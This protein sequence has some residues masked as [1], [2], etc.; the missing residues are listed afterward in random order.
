[1]DFREIVAVSVVVLIAGCG[2]EG[3]G[4]VEAPVLRPEPVATIHMD[5]TGCLSCEMCRATMRR[6]A[7]QDG[8]DIRFEGDA[9]E[10]DCR[11]EEP[12]SFTELVRRMENSGIR[13]LRVL[14]VTFTAVGSLREQE[15]R[16]VFVLEGNGQSLP[17]AEGADRLTGERQRARFKVKGWRR[18]QDPSVEVLTIEP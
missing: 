11:G 6:M 1:M 5:I 3:A 18:G 4:T 12:L 7:Q 14:G 15:G 8:G 9:I 10:I 2:G 17:I 13:N 16:P